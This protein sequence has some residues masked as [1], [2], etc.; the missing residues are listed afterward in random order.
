M[1]Y[2]PSFIY[3]PSDD[4]YQTL[5][6]ALALLK[7]TN[8]YTHIIEIGSGSGYIIINIAKR[9]SQFRRLIAT[10]INCS[11]A[12]ETVKNAAKDGLMNIDAVCCNLMDCV[13]PLKGSLVIFNTP[14]L[15][16]S[17][18]ELASGDPVYVSICRNYRGDIL[19]DVLEMVKLGCCDFVLTIDRDGLETITS[20]LEGVKP[21]YLLDIL[22][23]K[24]MFFE[25]V[26]TVHLTNSAQ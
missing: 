15:M 18:D 1:G 10:D 8:K 11:A 6:V 9:H 20:L 24:H 17:D 7:I 19:I 12:R 2:F 14:Y 13:R 26:I 4:T 3:E 23:N 21:R 25:D 22:Y 16:C 5:D